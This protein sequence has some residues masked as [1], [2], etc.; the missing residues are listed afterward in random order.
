MLFVAPNFS[1]ESMQ[2]WLQDLD[3]PLILIKDEPFS[4][5]DLSDVVL[6]ASGTA[7]LMVGL[8]EKPMVVMYRM[9]TTTAFLAKLFVKSTKYFGLINLVLDQLAVPELFQGQSDAP[10]LVRELEKLLDSASERERVARTLRPAKDRLG[11]KG[12]TARVARALE[13][14]WSR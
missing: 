2:V 14:Y 4:M 1:K 12:A 9:N 5:I 6:C 11:Q 3:F 8:L 7:T 13:E 10:H